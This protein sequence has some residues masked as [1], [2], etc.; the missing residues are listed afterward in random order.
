MLLKIEISAN[1]AAHH[2]AVVKFTHRWEAVF[3]AVL[4]RASL[5][6]AQVSPGQFGSLLID[7]GQAKPLNRTQMKRLIDSCEAG[8]DS[9]LGAGAFALRFSHVPRQR[10]VGPWRWVAQAGDEVEVV[11]AVGFA[12]DGGVAAVND[13]A[14]AAA[15]AQRVQ[16]LTENAPRL[17]HG[18]LVALADADKFAMAGDHSHA[19]DGY[20]ALLQ[21]TTLTAEGRVLLLIRQARCLK[22]A[23]EMAAMRA[24][25][26]EALDVADFGVAAGLDL[27]REHP[28]PN[29]LPRAV[30]RIKPMRVAPRRG[31]RTRAVALQ[32]FG[33]PGARFMAEYLLT[34]VDYDEAP[35]KN[36]RAVAATL[37]RQPPQ[38]VA[39]PYG[40]AEWH[41][42][43]GLAQRRVAQAAWKARDEA[44]DAVARVSLADEAQAAALLAWDHLCCSV[45]WALS[46]RDFDNVQNFLVNMGMHCAAMHDI[47]LRAGVEDAFAFYELSLAYA[48]DFACGEDTAWEHIV[49]GILWL[50]NPDLRE[51]FASRPT[52]LGLTDQA[53]RPGQEK[54]FRSMIDVARRKGDPRQHALALQCAF[55]FGEQLAKPRV[56]HDAAAEL[57]ALFKS[58]KGLREALE[59]AENLTLAKMLGW[60]AKPTR[61]AGR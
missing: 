44:A 12:W 61:R 53:S 32:H 55:R 4:Q 42:T 20:A 34:R 14:A 59:T 45:Y 41:N 33:D 46:S 1:A 54:F 22:R 13:A 30:E 28:H 2:G 47:G 60:G 39:M 6:D 19:A 36:F 8:I 15:P 57:R 37:G 52:M 26:R 25:L 38:P 16:L 7:V 3:L 35:A 27:T 18:F 24:V 50:D 51:R 43:M 9:L 58:K 31:R 11:A 48:G 23:G 10:T 21:G 56:Q 17:M 29:P 49:L 5:R 40:T